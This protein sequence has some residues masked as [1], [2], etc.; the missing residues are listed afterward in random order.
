M[1][2]L[3]GAPLVTNYPLYVLHCFCAKRGYAFSKTRYL[4]VHARNESTWK[5]NGLKLKCM[6]TFMAIIHKALVLS[7]SENWLDRSIDKAEAIVQCG[8]LY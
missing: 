4:T 3:E 1:D 5:S 6:N 8:P 7:G 2:L